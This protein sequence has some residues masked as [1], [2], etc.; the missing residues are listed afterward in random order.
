MHIQDPARRVFCA[1]VDEL[2]QAVS[3]VVD[4]L[5]KSGRAEN[6]LIVFLS[7]NGAGK[8][9]GGSNLGLR[10]AKG[11]AFEGGIRVPAIAWW[12]AKIMPGQ[13]ETP[14][15]ALDIAPTFLSV[16]GI[17]EDTLQGESLLELTNQVRQFRF[18]SRN[19]HWTNTAVVEGGLKYVRR[20]RND[21]TLTRELLFNLAEDPSEKINLAPDDP[22]RVLPFR[23]S[24]LDY[25]QTSGD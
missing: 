9:D 5:E 7:D 24:A 13:S 19:N 14:A 11:S 22:S 20:E 3:Q 17:S 6:T 16:A 8:E 23:Q 12:P 10:G 21:G 18:A 2:D 1:M 25:L 4:A 15:W